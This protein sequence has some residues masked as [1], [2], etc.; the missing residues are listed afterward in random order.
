MQG[1]H[2][3]ACPAADNARPPASRAGGLARVFVSML[4][5]LS[6]YQCL[7]ELCFPHLT[8]WQSHAVTIVGGSILATA[9]AALV[10]RDAARREAAAQRIRQGLRER[11]EQYRMVFDHATHGIYRTTPDGRILLANPALLDMLG[12]ASL[13]ELAAR[14]LET[15]GTE[16]DH[17]RA[18]FRRQLETEG[19][20]RGLEAVWVRKDG[21]KI[22]VRENAQLVRG[23]DGAP[24]F[25]EGSAEDV[26]ARKEAEEALRRSE[27]RFARN[28]ANVPGMMYQFVLHPDGNIEFP[29]VSDGCRDVYG[30]SPAEITADPASIIRLIHPGDALGFETSLAASAQTGLPWHW[31][32]RIVLPC[33]GCKWVKGASR[34]ESQ[35]NGDVVWDGLMM[36]ITQIKTVQE[37]LERSH[38]ELE[39]RVASRT[40][41]V[42][43]L[44]AEL[45]QA[46]DATIEGLSRAL[47]MRDRE[48]EGHCRRVTDLTLDLAHAM[49]LPPD[50]LV[51]ARRGALLHDIGKMGIPDRILLKPGPL[52]DEEWAIMRRHPSYAHEMLSPIGFLRPALDIPRFHH[53]KW[54]GTGYPHGLAGKCIPLAARLFAVVDVWDALLSDRPY[55]AGW[56]PARVRAHIQAGAGS[57]FDP[58]VVDTFLALSAVSTP[59]ADLPLSLAA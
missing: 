41:E 28:A 52:S 1:S 56:P 26:T 31:E 9:V 24:L 4:L 53:E 8:A 23:A 25:Y 57:H 33:G 55:R 40:R 42:I 20:V 39:D 54:D 29:F 18:D 2:S 10:G 49:G 46:Y 30:L 17:A 15:E 58:Q 59:A 11:E 35:P 6:A 21:R 22:F 16:A 50:D 3:S 12:F 13:E 43:G 37:A 27:A 44:N 48:T 36:D 19:H 34:P 45:T 7:K 32:G 51:Q 14:N 5:G 47:D 38:E